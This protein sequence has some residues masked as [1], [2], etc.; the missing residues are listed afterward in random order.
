MYIKDLEKMKCEVFTDRFEVEK[1][2]EDIFICDDKPVEPID[3]ADLRTLRRISTLKYGISIKAHF[4]DDE[5]INEILK[6]I[7]IHPIPV[8]K[9]KT[10]LIH[11]RINEAESSFMYENLGN[12]IQQISNLKGDLDSDGSF[13]GLYAVT[14][15]SL[16]PIGECYVNLVFGVDKTE[17]DKLEDDKHEQMIE[18]Y[19]KSKYPPIDFP[20]LPVDNEIH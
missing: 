13:D 7:E 15:S 20:E 3:Y 17:E 5:L 8:S 14:N 16:I 12:L 10:Y 19:H 6:V 11:I 9:L 1:M 2:A 4:S 18:E